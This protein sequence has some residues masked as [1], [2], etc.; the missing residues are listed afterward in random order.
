LFREHAAPWALNGG[1][2]PEPRSARSTVDIDLTSQG[3]AVSEARDTN[4]V[5]RETLQNAANVPLG[6]WFEYASERLLWIDAAPYAAPAFPWK[7]GWTTGS[8]GRFHLGTGI[9]VLVIE[10]LGT[11]A[12]RDWLGLAG[13]QTARGRM[14]AREQQFAEKGSRLHASTIVH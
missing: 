2:A 12:C 8:F 4:H 3:V 13:I 10:P 7:L 5:V 6:D 9:G 11:I 1:Y 14:I